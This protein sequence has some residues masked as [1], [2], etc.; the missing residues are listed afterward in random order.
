M[1][2]VTWTD[3]NSYWESWA[4]GRLPTEAEWEYG[5]RA[6]STAARYGELEAIAW[7]NLNSGGRIHPVKQKQ[8]NAWGFLD[9]FSLF[10]FWG[11]GRSSTIR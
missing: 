6:G 10:P 3:A 4:K 1:V 11:L 8:P 7:Y 5:A 9:S 2:N